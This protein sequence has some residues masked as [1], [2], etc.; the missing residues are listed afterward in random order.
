MKKMNF[1]LQVEHHIVAII[2]L[3]I[4]IIALSYTAWREEKTEKNRTLRFAGFEVLKNLGELQLVVNNAH[5]QE[6]KSMGD[7]F[8]GW[9]HISLISDMSRL[10]P[11]P[12][13]EKI[14]QLIIVWKKDWNSLKSSNESVE[15]ITNEIDVSRE[16]V[17]NELMHLN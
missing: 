3:I 9:G 1:G 5:Y 12:I 14:D 16:V 11:P 7:P 4:A 6:D 17:L 10:L 15:K 13:P 8:L 2:S